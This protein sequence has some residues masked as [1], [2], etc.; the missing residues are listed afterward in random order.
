MVEKCRFLDQAFTVASTPFS[1]GQ[2]TQYL[3]VGCVWGL[4]PFLLSFFLVGVLLFVVFFFFGKFGWV[5]QDLDIFMLVLRDSYFS[6]QFWKLLTVHADA[7]SASSFCQR[8]FKQSMQI[9]L[10]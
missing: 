4:V 10:C 7:A 1:R 6:H 5:F 8:L 3:T 2:F 9:G